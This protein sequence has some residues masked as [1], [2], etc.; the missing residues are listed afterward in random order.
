[1]KKEE[2]NIEKEHQEEEVVDNEQIHHEMDNIYEQMEQRVIDNGVLK[3]KNMKIFVHCNTKSQHYKPATFEIALGR[4]KQNFRWLGLVAAQRYKKSCKLNGRVRQREVDATRTTINQNVPTVCWTGE[5][6]APP[7]DPRMKLRD[8]L[9]HHSSIYFEFDRSLDSLEMKLIKNPRVEFD[10]DPDE[11]KYSSE[12]NGM[13]P[14]QGAIEMKGTE[15]YKDCYRTHPSRQRRMRKM[16]KEGK[17]VQ[18][19]KK[20]KK[21][22]SKIKSYHWENVFLNRHHQTK[23]EIIHRCTY[24]VKRS[25]IFKEKALVSEEEHEKVLQVLIK[26]YHH[27]EEIFMFAC[28]TDG[29]SPTNV[30]TEL[31]FKL[32]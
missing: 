9:V 6:N 3:R 22:I 25:K 28:A 12:R 21:K 16:H 10:E 19:K 2:E 31:E 8:V 15:W 11:P 23:K 7:M 18:K 5:T 20:K 32:F 30:M 4:G 26:H 27:I 14:P 24:E 13:L 1:M 29:Q 17:A